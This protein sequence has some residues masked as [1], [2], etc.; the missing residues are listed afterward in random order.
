VHRRKQPHVVVLDAVGRAL[1][2]PLERL[3]NTDVWFAIATALQIAAMAAFAVV[4]VTRR[5]TIGFVAL[6]LAALSLV[7]V[8]GWTFVF[9]GI[10]GL[11]GLR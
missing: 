7:L 11:S 8:L 9:V 5:D 6:G 1:H 4:W 2:H 10:K 3:L